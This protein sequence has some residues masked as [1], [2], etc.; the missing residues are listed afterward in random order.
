MK[1]QEECVLCCKEIS[2]YATGLC[3]H[4][5]CYECSARMRVLCE[6]NECPICRSEI[7]L[8]IFTEQPQ[9]FSNN[10][11][12][13]SS[14]MNKNYQ[15]VFESEEVKKSFDLLLISQC[16]ICQE[17]FP[18]FE[19]LKEHVRR[20][21]ELF[22]CE[23]C[24]N[25]LKI[26]T[27]ERK[28]YNRKDLARHKIK[29]D[30]DQTSHRGHP[31]CEYCDVRY[32]DHDDLFR[33]LR[34]EHFFCHF[35]DADGLHQYYQSYEYLRVHFRTDHYLCE[36][37]E[38][39]NEKFTA[40]FRSEIDLKAHT[41]VHH[42]KNKSK[43]EAREARKIDFKFNYSERPNGSSSPRGR[44][45][46]NQRRNAEEHNT[47]DK[48][49]SKVIPETEPIDTQSTQEFPFL[50]AE[51][52]L[53]GISSNGG[54]PVELATSMQSVVRNS[55][56][57]AYR[58]NMMSSE[59]FPALGPSSTSDLFPNQP[60]KVDFS[61]KAQL[62]R[63]TNSSRFNVTDDDR[64]DKPVTKNPQ[65]QST[66]KWLS[67]KDNSNFEEAFPRL[68]VK[69]S[70]PASVPVNNVKA[71][72]IQTSMSSFQLQTNNDNANHSQNTTSDQ[73]VVIK[74]KSKKKKPKTP[75][76]QEEEEFDDIKKEPDPVLSVNNFAYLNNIENTD[77][78]KRRPPSRPPKDTW[79]PDTW[80]TKVSFGKDDFPPLEEVKKPPPPP[81]INVKKSRPP[82]PG[83]S[84]N[85]NANTKS[86][87]SLSSIAQIVGNSLKSNLNSPTV[88]SFDLPTSNFLY[89]EPPN[90]QMRNE[91][92]L[93]LINE[94]SQTTDRFKEF[95][96]VSRDFRCNAI[97]GREYQKKCLDILEEDDYR[98]IFPELV[99][100]L[101]DIPKQQELLAVHNEYLNN[102]YSNSK[103]KN[104]KSKS[105][106]LSCEICNQ[107]LVV[108]DCE[109]HK[110]LE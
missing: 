53:S 16:Q 59:D 108:D 75:F 72:N 10:G 69:K 37:G 54:K 90:F 15:I 2:I 17:V 29:G 95:K 22:Y 49:Q 28:C 89:L 38:C 110:C 55:V 33:H 51:E 45:Y 101:P 109:S 8:V 40:V 41:A 71:A 56:P 31:L 42:S 21:H 60:K 99:A 70:R 1:N 76:L 100:L 52:A 58:R 80:Q 81:G 26:F 39:V 12:K 43:A 9:P 106:I 32:V 48:S 98:S 94:A 68:E 13:K 47:N 35:C 19:K 104:F 67:K 93:H 65:Q 4:P 46:G 50:S 61:A 83:F 73:F 23:I 3:D 105:N 7:P 87:L 34:R 86:S 66:P 85:S 57:Q 11:N 92:L 103:R 91:R 6:T 74:S 20:K 107:V 84:T 30:P 27:F 63:N 102:Y 14:L 96:S 88:D 5:V 78:I 97:S 77:P 18:S 25:S 82:P 62:P 79:E 64:M 24:N 36:E 44:R